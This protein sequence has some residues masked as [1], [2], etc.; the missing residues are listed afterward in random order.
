MRTL[1]LMPAALVIAFVG[2]DSGDHRPVPSAKDP[3]PKASAAA[4]ATGDSSKAAVPTPKHYG[5]AFTLTEAE[6]LA[7]AVK[8]ADTTE[9]AAA[10]GDGKACGDDGAKKAATGDKTAAAAPAATADSCSGLTDQKGTL[11]RVRGTVESVCQSAGCWLVLQDNDTKVRIFTKDHGFFLPTTIKGAKAEVEGQLRARTITKKF[12][13]HL[14]K[15]N[16]DDPSEVTGPRREYIMT[17]SAVA[18]R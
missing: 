6:S 17:A 8:R 12:A 11:V 13:K 10:K 5:K 7:T 3:T 14:A 16:G 9:A 1:M 18:L 4:A 15:D 2:C